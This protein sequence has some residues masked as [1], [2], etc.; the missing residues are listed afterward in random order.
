[1]ISLPLQNPTRRN[2]QQVLCG[3][4]TATF[5]GA[6][7]DV[8]TNRPVRILHSHAELYASTAAAGAGAYI[9]TRAIR[10]PLPVRIFAGVFTSILA[11]YCSWTYGLRLPTWEDPDKRSSSDVGKPGLDA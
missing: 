9:L 10:A 8:L 6:T 1:M 5:G 4:S 7:R 2:V 3:M 11:R